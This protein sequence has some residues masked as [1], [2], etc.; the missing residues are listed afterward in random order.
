[1]KNAGHRQR[2]D[3]LAQP[4]GA[5][6]AQPLDRARAA[7]ENGAA[8]VILVE[9][10]LFY[11]AQDRGPRLDLGE[12]RVERGTYE[13][14]KFDGQPFTA[15][16]YAEMLKLAGVDT[17]LTVHNQSYAVEKVYGGA[18]EGRYV[19]LM[20]YPIYAD[21][22]RNSNI[23]EYGPDGEGLV[24][25]APD[26]GA[27]TFVKEMFRAL[28]LARA[29]IVLLDKRRSSEREVS[30]QLHEESETTF[31]S[32]SGSD[33]VLMDDMVRTGST[34]VETCRFLKQVKPRRI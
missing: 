22:L 21:Y 5:R 24:L 1:G 27:T 17:V 29:R 32:I 30:I 16:L 33:I 3:P 15:K 23:V 26:L 6:D 13:L 11:S 14:K 31:Q 8:H 4:P 25:C 34:V 12:T 9:P 7:K 18:F 20:P 10:D 2:L 28:G 19:N